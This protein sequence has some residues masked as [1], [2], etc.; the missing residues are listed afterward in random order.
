MVATEAALWGSVKAHGFLPDHAQ[1]CNVAT[2]ML[3]KIEPK[4]QFRP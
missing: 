3:D 2:I 4:N 1:W